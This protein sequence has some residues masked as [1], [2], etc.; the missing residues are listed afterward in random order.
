[1]AILLFA[2]KVTFRG[3]MDIQSPKPE[4][5]GLARYFGES[6]A[7][8]WDRGL[9]FLADTVGAI[10]RILS[11]GIIWWVLL[12]AVLLILRRY[13]RRPAAAATPPT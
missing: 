9:T 1:M 11:G 6:I 2:E 10:V 7:N 13:L 4:E 5:P 3:S 8:A 12:I